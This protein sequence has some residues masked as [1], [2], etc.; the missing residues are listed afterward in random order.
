MGMKIKNHTAFFSFNK[1]AFDKDLI[2]VIQNSPLIL[3]VFYI[4]PLYLNSSIQILHFWK[5]KI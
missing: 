5:M 3:K 1:G 2:C 4:Y